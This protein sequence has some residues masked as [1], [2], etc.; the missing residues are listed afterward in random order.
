ML[1][2][3]VGVI[4]KDP[5]HGTKLGVNSDRLGSRCDVHDREERQRK[6]RSGHAASGIEKDARTPTWACECRRIELAGTLSLS[7]S[8]SLSLCGSFV[9]SLARSLQLSQ[10]VRPV[11][12]GR[13]TCLQRTYVRTGRRV[14]TSFVH[15]SSLLDLPFISALQCD[16]YTYVV[17][18]C[19]RRRRLA[20]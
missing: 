10:P 14:F 2:R 11:F 16:P 1:Y 9:R 3:R 8:L 15:F 19:R 5:R 13:S 18:C 7:L 4:V 20:C 6:R 12:C 17:T